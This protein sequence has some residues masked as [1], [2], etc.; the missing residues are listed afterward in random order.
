MSLD[1]TRQSLLKTLFYFVLL[2]VIFWGAELV[3]PAR[4]GVVAAAHAAPVVAPTAGMPLGTLID[5]WVGFVPGIGILLSSFL[6]FVNSFFVTRIVIRNVIFLERTYMPAIIYLLVSSGYYNSYMSFRPLL[7]AFL[8][9]LAVEM[10]FRSYN[11]KGLATG[12]YLTIGFILGVA[13]VI[14]APVLLLVALIPVG[15]VI[16]RLFDLREWVA[17]FGGWLLPMFFSAY[18]VW[19]FGGE[20]LSVFRSCRDALMTPL[21]LPAARLFSSFEWTFIGCMAVLFVLSII[22]FL[23]R[24]R[25][26][27]LKPFK[28]YIF[29]IWMFVVSVLILVFVPC[30]SLYQLPILAIP[31]SVIIPTYFNSRKPNFLSNFLYALLMGCAVVIHLLPFFL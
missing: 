10:I 11:F 9:L 8:L 12:Q 6:V 26:Y 17:A 23:G 18:V 13:G 27:K 15:F 25:S 21:K 4:S 29:F 24:S 5:S 16:F 22:T 30:R 31:L 14:Y 1:L 19:C 7:V 28:V 20:F 3:Q 2:A